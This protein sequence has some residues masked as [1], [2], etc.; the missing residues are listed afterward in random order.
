MS[1]CIKEFKPLMKRS[2]FRIFQVIVLIAF[3]TGCQAPGM[4]AEA[5]SK[6][7]VINPPVV[8]PAAL[9]DFPQITSRS[10]DVPED[11]EA[12]AENGT[13]RL[14]MRRASSAIIVE[15]LRSGKIWR[16]SPEGLSENRGTTTAWRRQIE[17]PVQ[18]AHVDAGRDQL[19]NSKVEREAKPVIKPVQDGARV[20]YNLENL[21]L[22]FDVVFAL[23][24]DCLYATIPESSVAESGDTGLITID[25]LAFFGAVQDGGDGYIVFPDGSGAL[26]RFDTPHP[27]EVQK[28]NAVIY[29]TDATGGTFFG[30]ANFREQ[31]TMPL[32]G[33]VQGS[34]ENASGFVG[35]VTNGDFDSSIGVARS[36]KGINYNHVWTTFIFRRQGRFSLT[37][38]Q[39]AW[40]YQPDRI[41]GDRSVRY[42]FLDG[43]DA[44]YVKMGE[45]YRTFLLEE[46]GAKRIGVKTGGGE[47]VEG[48]PE[49]PRMHISFFMGTERRTWFLSDMIGMTSFSDAQRILDDLDQAGVRG[50]DISLWSWNMGG[51]AGKWPQRFPVDERLGGEDGLRA[52]ADSLH[53]RGQRLFLHDDYI[54][55]PP[56]AQGV[57]PYLDAARGVDGLPVGDDELGY[58]LNPQVALRNFAVRDIPKMVPLGA[59][60]LELAGLGSLTIPDKNQVYPLSRESFA[61]SYMQIGGISRQLFGAVAI[62]GANIYS[63]PYADR[64]DNIPIDSTHYDLFDD[65]VPLYSIVAHGL[66]QYTHQP[67][68]LISDG[69]RL[70]LRQIEYGAIPYFILTKNN[71]AQLMRTE[72]SNIY[73]SEYSHWRDEI[74]RQY[75]AMEKMGQVTGQFI[76]G[77]EKLSDTVSQT[78][79]EDGT[80]VIVN[81]GD[82]PFA[83]GSMSVPANDFVVIGGE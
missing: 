66:V 20:T 38:G 25:L 10:P 5:L 51:T 80:R 40:L 67:Y 39:P 81:Y 70:F 61:A 73:S 43:E 63:V 13:L 31:V 59:D 69:K 62:Q 27:E 7:P 34:G 6:A 9:K 35:M 33:M 64:L 75:E 82:V 78:T 19:K 2:R 42:C 53:Q 16:S 1:A 72:A 57:T 65:T 14:Y 21:K 54:G 30:P 36:G 76:T 26:M 52:L 4:S 58:L 56:R 29:G 24:E 68:N 23:N 44:S 79:F 32:Y 28:I 8:L 17:F 46:R 15:N 77:H 74:I 11:Y 48:A 3:L 22:K 49:L 12:V 55:V 50:V 45:R 60:G 18:V 41:T 71:S 37:G 47:A 83:E